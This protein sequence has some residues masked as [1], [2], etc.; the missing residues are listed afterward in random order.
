MKSSPRLSR[1]FW[2]D[3]SG[4]SIVEFALVLPAFLTL[5]V[6]GF[7]LALL[8][9]TVSN[10]HYA[11]EAGARCAS[12]QTSTCTNSTTT[13]AFALSRFYNAGGSGA[14]FT[15]SNASCGH[16]VSGTMTYR[17]NTGFTS[18]NIPLSARACFP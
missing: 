13:A 10:M 2:T 8:G 7:Y 9:F 4:N 5:I 3:S 1:S 14:T 15:S 16:L 6:G 17:L 18:L 11:A 12:V